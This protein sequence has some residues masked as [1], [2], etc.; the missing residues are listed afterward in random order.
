MT[1]PFF[2]SLTWS[3]LWF[4]FSF[5]LFYRLNGWHNSFTVNL[6]CFIVVSRV[7]NIDSKPIEPVVGR[8]KIIPDFVL[9]NNRENNDLVF[10]SRHNSA[11]S[12]T[13]IGDQSMEP[14][15]KAV[16]DTEYRQSFTWNKVVSQNT[17]HLD[18]PVI[19]YFVSLLLIY[20]VFVF[21]VKSIGIS[22]VF[23]VAY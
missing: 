18:D 23:C 17:S 14:S 21:E 22:F 3:P 15:D 12:H 9:V 19:N 11:N 16:P 10:T 6:L 2:E 5:R 8:R 1:Q 13:N 4:E 7:V 20:W